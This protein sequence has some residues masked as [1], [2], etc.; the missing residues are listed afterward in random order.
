MTDGSSSTRFHSIALGRSDQRCVPVDEHDAAISGDGVRCV[1]LAMGQHDALRLGAH[2]GRQRVVGVERACHGIGVPASRPARRI[3]ERPELPR[4]PAAA[5]TP[6][7]APRA[8]R[9]RRSPSTQSGG[10]MSMRNAA[11]RDGEPL[12]RGERVGELAV[13]VVSPRTSGYTATTYRS[14]SS[15]AICPLSVRTG[16]TTNSNPES[17]NSPAVAK[18]AMRCSRVLVQRLSGSRRLATRSSTVHEQVV[19]AVIASQWWLPNPTAR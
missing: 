6:R 12:P 3:G 15:W 14:P 7:T 16:A 4:G 1:R 19:D 11:L 18:A 10:T 9:S 2:L 8:G 17:R 13:V 5:H